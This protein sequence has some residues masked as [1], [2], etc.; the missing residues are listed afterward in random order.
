VVNTVFPLAM[1]LG[2][3]KVPWPRTVEQSVEQLLETSGMGIAH[4]RASSELLESG[5]VN[6]TYMITPKGPLVTCTRYDRCPYNPSSP[7]AST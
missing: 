3:T 6:S 5:V 1:V 7:R 2:T 4:G